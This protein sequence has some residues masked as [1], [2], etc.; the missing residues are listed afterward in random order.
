MNAVRVVDQGRIDETVGRFLRCRADDD[1]AFAG[2]VL[3]V[4]WRGAVVIDAAY[5]HA[6]LFDRHGERLPQPRPMTCD[7]PF[8]LASLTKVVAT[9]T[10]AATLFEEGVVAPQDP[11]CS[12]LPDFDRPGVRDVLLA[13]L[14][15]HTSGLP[16]WLPLY[17]FV[18][19]Q[20]E[21]MA[22][23]A[24]LPATYPRGWRRVYSDVNFMVL[25]RAL[26]VAAG[27]PLQELFRDR[28]ARPLGL[29]R[30]GYAPPASWRGACAATSLGNRAE[31]HMCV[32][33]P[34]VPRPTRCP[35]DLPGWRRHVLVGEVNDAN[36]HLVFDGVAGH[37]GLFGPARDLSRLAES[38]LA[39][40]AGRGD[41]LLRPDTAH[42]VT[43]P[44]VTA[45]QGLGWWTSRI[46][47]SPRTFGHRGFTGTQL[48]I[49]PRNE[50][51]LVLL[52]NRVHGLL[53]YA[54]PERFSGPIVAAVYR[55]LGL[56]DGVVV[57][58]WATPGAA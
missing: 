43:T 36:A 49:D 8:D 28:V 55:E 34:F 5:G 22:L 19:G 31:E 17:L 30:M 3:R 25:G 57:D 4:T 7:T 52:T 38:L 54:A 16:N 53:P 41:G 11:L 12:L 58:P 42:F 20:E 39:S 23:L 32:A 21:A 26:E 47:A 1:G 35:A 33:R 2:A 24:S 15:T 9:A 29:Q 46:D 14:L 56:A 40:L 18:E 6:E 50:V 13:D 51:A 44:K 45:G 10:L 37:A 27:R 48:F